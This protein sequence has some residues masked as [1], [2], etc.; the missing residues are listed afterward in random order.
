MGTHCNS[1]AKNRNNK[2]Q[3]IYVH[4]DGY[5]DW[6]LDILRKY[7]TNDEIIHK[8]MDLGDLSSLNQSPECPVGH[9]FSNPVDGYCVAYVRDRGE[10]IPMNEFATLDEA[11][12]GSSQ[13]YRYI[14]RDGQWEQV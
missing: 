5:P 1:I 12:D 4:W 7:Y 2:W 14:Y 3:S 8:L 10:S 9:T 11:I 13:N 6:S